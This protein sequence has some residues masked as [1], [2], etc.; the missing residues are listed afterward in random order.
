VCPECDSVETES[1]GQRVSWQAEYRCCH[2]D[3]RWG[4]DMGTRYGY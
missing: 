1:N 4:M 2:C 3:H